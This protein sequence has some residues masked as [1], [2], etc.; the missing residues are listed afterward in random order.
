MEILFLQIIFMATRL[1]MSS[2]FEDKMYQSEKQKSFVAD[3][4]AQVKK[5]SLKTTFQKSVLM[6]TTCITTFPV[7]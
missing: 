3:L 4:T 2:H 7:H 1:A 6:F 5:D